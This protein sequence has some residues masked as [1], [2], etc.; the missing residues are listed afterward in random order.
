MPTALLT[1]A[2]S[3][4]YGCDAGLASRLVFATIVASG[5][6]ILAMFGVLG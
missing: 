4:R 6:T 2:L 5:A 3:A 1:V